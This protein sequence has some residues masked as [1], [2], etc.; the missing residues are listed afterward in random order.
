MTPLRKRILDELEI[1]NYACGTIKKYV[2]AVA[3]YALYFK[4]SPEDL[5]PE[6]VRKY[7]VFLVQEKHVSWTVY[8]QVV[9][10]LRFLYRKVLD[11]DW[12]IAHIPF[13][14]HEKKLP[15]V[16]SPEEVSQFL[17]AV[18]HPKHRTVLTVMYAAG[19]RLSEALHLKLTDVD[20]SRMML[21]VEQGKG[22]KDRYVP[23]SP[24]LLTTLRDYW[25]LYQSK[26]WLFP[27]QPPSNPISPSGVQTACSQA[28]KK[29]GMTKRVHSHTLRHCFATHLL[30]GG[31]DLRTI[32]LFLGHRSLNTTA[33]YLHIARKDFNL[34][35]HGRDL[36]AKLTSTKQ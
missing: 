14:K 11:K 1:R 10:A 36:L 25:K 12:A 15:V 27:G 16:L 8:N 21:R 6:D 31:T 35:E 5:G 32:Q 26:D 13:P 17:A 23:L 9:C 7:Q 30:E 18:D 29:A 4:Q 3:H 33:R 19:L 22:K 28:R 24:S 34:A 20:S 2:D